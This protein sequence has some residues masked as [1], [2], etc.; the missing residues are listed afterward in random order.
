MKEN[1]SGAHMPSQAG[2]KGTPPEEK[3]RD[4]WVPQGSSEPQ[5]PHTGSNCYENSGSRSEANY[6]HGKLSLF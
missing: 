5:E 3:E 6:L 2:M 4:S 1:A